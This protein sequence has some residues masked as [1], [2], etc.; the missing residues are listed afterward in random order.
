MPVEFS[1]VRWLFTPSLRSHDISSQDRGCIPRCPVTFLWNTRIKLICL[2]ASANP[3]STLSWFSSKLRMEDLCSNSMGLWEQHSCLKGELRGILVST[4]V[5]KRLLCSFSQ[6]LEHEVDENCRAVDPSP[7]PSSYEILSLIVQSR[8]FSQL[9]SCFNMKSLHYTSPH[10]HSVN[11]DIT[12]AY[13]TCMNR[14]RS[15]QEIEE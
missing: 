8:H 14:Q 7:L 10:D 5:S 13:S 9:Y 6:H 3:Q 12:R 11:H 1:Q 4:W 15:R 2:R